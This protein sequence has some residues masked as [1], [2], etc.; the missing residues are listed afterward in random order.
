MNVSVPLLVEPAFLTA[1][2]FEATAGPEVARLAELAGMTPDPEQRLA[3]DLIFAIGPDGKSAAFEFAVV[4]SRQNLKTAT[5]KM[6]AL[7]WLFITGEQLVVWSAHEFPTAKE[8]LRDLAAMI[9][10]TPCLSRLLKKNGI[11]YANDDPSIELASGQRLKFKARTLSGGRGLTGDKVILDEAFALTADHMGALLPTLSVRPDPQ[12]LYGSSAGLARSEVLRGI[13]DRGRA[14]R[15]DRLAYLEWSAPRKACGS[16]KCSHEVGADGCEL[17]VVENWAAANPLLGRTRANGTG[18]SVEYVRAERDALPPGEF[19]RERLGWWDESGADE[20]FG[21]GNW[22]ACVGVR[23]VGLV[24]G[25]LAVAVSYDL[26]HATVAGAGRDGERVF[27]VPLQHGPGTGWVVERV[28]ELQ[29]LHKVDVVIDGHGPAADLVEPLKRAGVGLHVADTGD[30]LD[31]YAGMQKAVRGRTFVHEEFPELD[32][33]AAAAVPRPVGD[34][35]AWGRKQSDADISPL[36]AV[37]LAVWA[38][39]R[40]TGRSAY[41]DDSSTLMVI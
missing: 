12:V 23:P 41:E 8:A 18:L 26:Q 5:F 13:R 33:A 3:L 19:A 28:E 7:G 1:P 4:C 38:A 35:H 17:D 9:D 16:E 2:V 40:G 11:R 6:A 21:P 25:G 15:S 27:G 31:G 22:E 34:R 10:G 37:T 32:A 20:A 29:A 24:L 14:G 30:V 36:E 39:S